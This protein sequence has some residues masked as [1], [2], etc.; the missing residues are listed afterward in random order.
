[1]RI[2]F[3]AT[4]LTAAGK[5]MARFQAEFL[6]AAAAHGLVADLDVFVPA[7]ADPA[8]LPQRAGWRYHTV[9]P[10]PM[11]V[12]E[13][14]R[15][16]ALARQLD[17]D[18]VVTLSERA[19]LWGPPQVVYVYEH[20]KH[21]ARRLREVGTTPR[22]RLVDLT[23]L[24]LFPLALR[25]AAVVLAASASTARDLA[26]HVRAAR[27]AYSGVSAAFCP[28][29]EERV[30]L[31]HI[32]SDDPRDNSHVVVEAYAQLPEP[33]P[34]LVVAGPI[35][36]ERP[37]LERLAVSL[38]V[39]GAISWPG[40]QRG[41]D[42]VRLYRRSIAYVDPSL[43]EGFGLQA[44]EALACGTPVIA[45]NTTSLPEVVGDGGILLDPHD[46]AGFASAMAGL[47]N[48][49]DLARRLSARAVEQASRF[50]WEATARAVVT[51][52]AEAARHTD[53]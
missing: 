38:G 14:L 12:W 52:C 28:G 22:Q 23:T 53:P 36:S 19:A 6:R 27:V 16:P 11:I 46:V 32:A 7:D 21:R 4:S 18:V 20:P 31:L 1:V 48:D 49:A 8:A 9:E 41:D 17:V 43:Y 25:R 47:A 3:D 34:P 44:A 37:A 10:R 50:T 39:D 35:A 29:E 15:R 51:A 33:R 40:F 42:L 45:S 2:G 30:H 13:Q 26:P 24:A 5:G